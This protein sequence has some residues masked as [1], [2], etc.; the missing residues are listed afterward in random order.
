V[1][2]VGEGLVQVVSFGKIGYLRADGTWLWPLA[3]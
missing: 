1:E 3:E 2:A